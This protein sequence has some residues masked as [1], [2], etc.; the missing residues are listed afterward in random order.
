MSKNKFHKWDL[1]SDEDICIV[2]GVK[3]RKKNVLNQ[4]GLRGFIITE[5]F[6]NGKWTSDNNNQNKLCHGA[7]IISNAK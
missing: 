5:Y 4:G 3:R 6:I 2:C 1:G 7:G